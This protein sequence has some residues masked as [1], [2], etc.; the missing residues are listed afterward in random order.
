MANPLC[1]SR[2]L[3]S[4]A[5]VHLFRLRKQPSGNS[6]RPRINSA[7]AGNRIMPA[8]IIFGDAC[9]GDITAVVDASAPGITILFPNK[10]L[11]IPQHDAMPNARYDEYVI[12]AGGTVTLRYYWQAQHANGTWM[13]FGPLHLIFTPSAGENYETW[14]PFENG[15]FQ[16]PELNR[17][18]YAT[19]GNVVSEPAAI[20]NLLRYRCP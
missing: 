8:K 18:S 16:S 19:D 9:Q 7:P 4:S 15:S 10:T 1:F 14:A 17:V 11:G 5:G 12:P 3:G 13:R 20:H 6:I 2:M